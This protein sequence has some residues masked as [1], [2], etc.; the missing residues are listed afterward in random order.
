[1]ST[2]IAM[3]EANGRLEI[4]KELGENGTGVLRSW[5]ASVGSYTQNWEIAMDAYLGDIVLPESNSWININLVAF[6]RNDTNLVDGVPLG[7]GMSIALDLYRWD[8]RTSRGYELTSWLNGADLYDVPNY[9]YVST[10][11][12]QGR[13]KISFDA[14]SKVLT[15]SCNGNVLG[16]VDVDAPGSDWE[17]T[18]GD[19]F[20]FAIADSLESPLLALASG[21]MHAD[22]FMVNGTVDPP[23]DGNGNGLPDWWEKLYYIDP[24]LDPNALCANGFNTIMDAYIAGFD[25][26][27]PGGWF[28]ITGLDGNMIQWDAV[29]G[30]VYSVYW[31]TNLMAGFQTLETNYTGGTFTD[32][33][34]SA[35]K[36][37]F[38]KIDVR[39]P[40]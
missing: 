35:E 31:S 18:D 11:D 21:D 40:Q 32:T 29:S 17:M 5:V 2:N 25:P 23:V 34:H 28:G 8:G 36:K 27:D 38:Y 1:S 19:L 26:T 10:A 6:N 7:D 20:G 16:W 33:L 24:V 12:L 14:T 39:L 9:G 30:R 13:L 3:Q 22:N 4:L 37:C 15:A